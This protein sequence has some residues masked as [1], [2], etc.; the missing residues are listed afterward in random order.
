VGVSRK[1]RIFTLKNKR[2]MPG[3]LAWLFAVLVKLIGRTYRV[4]VRDDAGLL[5]D[6]C[7]WPV[8][9]ALWHNRLL[10]LAGCFPRDLR[11]RSAVL[12]S[13]S[14]D[15][16]Y[17]SSFIRHFDMGVVRGSSSRR[18]VG[19]L[20]ELM[21]TLSEGTAVVL[22]LDGPRGPRYDIHHGALALA[23]RCG[24]PIVPISLNA[25]RRKELRSWDRTQIPLP[26][27]RVELCV[28][29]PVRF[30]DLAGDSDSDWRALAER[31]LREAMSAVTDDAGG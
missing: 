30:D 3:W 9:F 10:F 29:S 4:R 24:V 26:F 5:T 21:R 6:T 1:R 16:E 7:P 2:R 20:R 23:F 22:T 18:A 14:R 28:G 31:R 11:R 15:G 27:S 17:A 8:V 12:I 25:P 13:A 19:A